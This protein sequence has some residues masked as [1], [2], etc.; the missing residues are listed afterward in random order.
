MIFNRIVGIHTLATPL[1]KVSINRFNNYMAFSSIKQK[2]EKYL[3]A[4]VAYRTLADADPNRLYTLQ[5]AL[6]QTDM[7]IAYGNNTGKIEYQPFSLRERVIHNIN[8]LMVD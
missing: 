3:C 5:T 2:A 6:N 7:A 1:A 8:K 4:A